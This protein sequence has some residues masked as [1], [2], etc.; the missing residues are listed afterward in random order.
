M[1]GTIGDQVSDERDSKQSQVANEV[2]GFVPDELIGKPQSGLVEHV[3]VR[4]ND[5]IFKRSPFAQ[6]S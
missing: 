6:T 4:E 5:R 3:A 1:S 2:K